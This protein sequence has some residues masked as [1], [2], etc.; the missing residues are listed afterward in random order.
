MG[1][2]HGLRSQYVRNITADPR[3]RLLIGSRWYTGTAHLMPDDDPRAGLR[4]LPWFNSL[5]V[6]ALGTDLLTVRIGLGNRERR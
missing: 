5:M 3:V 1:S 2:D 4:Q 6:R